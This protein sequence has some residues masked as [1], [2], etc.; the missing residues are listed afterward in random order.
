MAVIEW[1][2]SMSIGVY[3][4]DKRHKDLV[5]LI[6]DIASAADNHASNV[7]I[8]NLVRRFYDYTMTHFRE[9]ESLMDHETYPEYFQQVTE[10]L[11]CSTK[12]IEYHRKIAQGEHFDILEMLT[13]LTNWFIA[14]TTGIDQTL[15]K[16]LIS[17]NRP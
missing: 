16:Y 12:A 4:I 9:E 11:E 15:T 5:D 13:Y 17:C 3:L 1:N 2:E 7:E 10:H 6:N 14:H 8:S